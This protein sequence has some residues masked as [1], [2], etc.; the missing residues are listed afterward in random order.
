[1]KVFPTIP[2]TDQLMVALSHRKAFGD[3]LV[4]EHDLIW[5]H[6]QACAPCMNMA[7]RGMRQR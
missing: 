7:L 2:I 3:R 4:S 5:T 1:M 6:L